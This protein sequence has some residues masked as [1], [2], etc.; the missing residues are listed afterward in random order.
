MQEVIHAFG[1]DWRLLLIQAVNFFLLLW[2]LKH[3][4]YRPVLRMLDERRATISEGVRAAREASERVEQVALET[5]TMRAAAVK[6]ADEVMN[7]ARKSA[8][9]EGEKMLAEAG[10]RGEALMTQAKTE[11][12]RERERALKEAER[13]V[14]RLSI[15]AAEKVLRSRSS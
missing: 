15:L 10:A 11:A 8:R 7:A 2:V 5:Q 3:F 9:A 12:A 14:A 6:E 13:E 1:I 4:V